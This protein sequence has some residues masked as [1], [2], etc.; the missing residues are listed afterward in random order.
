MLANG[1]TH[2]TVYTR[3]YVRTQYDEK[4]HGK[5]I[6]TI[7]PPNGGQDFVVLANKEEI[8]SI[9]LFDKEI[10]HVQL[11]LAKRHF[12]YNFK[13]LRRQYRAN[14]NWNSLIIVPQFHHR[15][16]TMVKSPIKESNNG[17]PCKRHYE[18]FLGS[19]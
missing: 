15:A 14:P 18:L 10:H 4:W 7:L 2:G 6:G 16:C 13:F 19:P 12:A 11:A 5:M 8:L 9:H 17:L 3:T 1:H